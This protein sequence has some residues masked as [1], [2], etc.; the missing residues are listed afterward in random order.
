MTHD[1]SANAS[2]HVGARVAAALVR[3]FLAL[4]AWATELSLVVGWLLITAGIA[5]LTSSVAWYFSL[6]LLAI[7]L[8]GWKVV[9]GIA[10]HGVDG[11]DEQQAA[12]RG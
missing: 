10:W 4:S 2:V 1:D 9:I 8:G 5:R 12:R 3:A 11:L 7:S 6:G